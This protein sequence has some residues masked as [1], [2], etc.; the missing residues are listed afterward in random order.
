ME[1]KLF[2]RGCMVAAM[3]MLFMACNS[4]QPANKETT[5]QE[6]GMQQPSDTATLQKTDLQDSTAA[7]TENEK[8]E[9]EKDEK[10]DD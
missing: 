5:T 1:N 4:E 2:L 10:D 7:K 3:A 9:N 6:V 8:E